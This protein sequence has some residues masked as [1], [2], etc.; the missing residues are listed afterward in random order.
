MWQTSHSLSQMTFLLSWIKI[1]A[2]QL[3]LI[4]NL[5]MPKNVSAINFQYHLIVT[6][7]HPDLTDWNMT[8][9]VKVF[10][11][12]SQTIRKPSLF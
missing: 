10:C 2:R 1:L 5:D 8:V 7:F 4:R 3:I 11:H 9:L 12:Q 6:C